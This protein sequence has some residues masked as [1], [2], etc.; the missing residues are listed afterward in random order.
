MHEFKS[1]IKEVRETQNKVV[2]FMNFLMAL[3][4][5][6][7]SFF[8]LSMFNFYY[9]GISIT[10]AMI[11][12]AVALHK[13]VNSK[14]LIEIEKKNPVLMERLRTAADYENVVNYVVS[15]L[16]MGV[17]KSLRDVPISSFIDIKKITYILL[18]IIVASGLVLFATSNDM[19]IYDLKS[20]LSTLSFGN[21]K[22]VLE[23]LVPNSLLEADV[24]I[25]DLNDDVL[26]NEMALSTRRDNGMRDLYLPEDI[27]EQSDKSFEE[28]LPKKKRIY[29]RKYFGEIRK[30][31]ID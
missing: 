14:N 27:F 2:L 30:Y 24:D 5:F 21:D 23:G 6:L 31:G 29:I 12:F 17:L 20:G 19:L 13:S 16:H 25:E 4:V 9:W 7:I 1:A 22:N 3:L 28:L 15:K 26:I 8:V 11:F 18:A 10:I